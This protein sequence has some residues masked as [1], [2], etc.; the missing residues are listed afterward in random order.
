MT[1]WPPAVTLLDMTNHGPA[2]APILG[3]INRALDR[4]RAPTYVFERAATL[5]IETALLIAGAVATVRSLPEGIA[6]AI[7][8]GLQLTATE[9]RREEA[10]VAARHRERGAITILPLPLHKQA[11]ALERAKALKIITWFWPS[12]IMVVAAAP[13]GRVAW[14]ALVAT[15]AALVRAAW[16]ELVMPLWRRSRVLWRARQ[17]L[18]PICTW[19]DKQHFTGKNYCQGACRP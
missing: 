17:Q 13:S 10:S 7:V 19:C 12:A 14:P 18:L 1:G 3:A 8:A 4:A 15:I 2:P 11:R 16:S 5:A 9:L 6:A